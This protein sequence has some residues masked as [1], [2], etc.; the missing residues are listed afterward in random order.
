MLKTKKIDYSNI[1]IFPIKK[2]SNPENYIVE[3]KRLEKS[4]SIFEYIWKETSNERY[5]KI[6]ELYEKAGNIYKISDKSK[7]IKCLS[8]SYNYLIL[9]LDSFGSNEYKIKKI[10][11]DIAE[12]YVKIDYTKSIEYYGKIINHYT[13]KGD[14]VNI[15]KIYEI[16]GNIYFDNNEFKK[17]NEIY[18]KTIEIINSNDKSIDIKKNIIDKIGEIYYSD[19]SVVNHF[20]LAKLYYS[21]SE[22]YLKKKLG[23]L[24]ATIFNMK[25]YNFI[26]K[27]IIMYYF[28]VF[29]MILYYIYYYLALFF[30]LPFS[31]TISSF[32]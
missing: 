5:E 31:F 6:S 18:S 19:E 2:M 26:L 25:L 14:V 28:V 24:T 27:H 16:I 20:E 15:I 7:A 10:L 23:Y 30:L 17:A 3:A 1:Y 4:K 8:K 32:I 9:V 29:C 22:D 21:I 12:L 11:S 13:E